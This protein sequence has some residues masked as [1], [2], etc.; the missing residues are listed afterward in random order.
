MDELQTRF[1]MAIENLVG[2]PP[3]RPP[4]HQRQRVR[5]VPLDADNRD[6]GIRQ[7]T[8]HIG[9][10]LDIFEFHMTPR[11]T[12]GAPVK[13]KKI[14]FS[15]GALQSMYGFLTSEARQRN[16]GLRPTQKP[17]ACRSGRA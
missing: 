5:T 15:K 3:I 11:Q 17:V 8:A 10:C 9:F 4:I 1:V 12:K 14:Q 7:D 16:V 13:G 6:S 2:H